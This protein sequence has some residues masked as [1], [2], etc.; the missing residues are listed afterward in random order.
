MFTNVAA[1][2]HFSYLRYLTNR[3]R[4]QYGFEGSPIRLHVRRRARVRKEAAS[5]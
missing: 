3:L 4:E 2:L 1:T 5:R